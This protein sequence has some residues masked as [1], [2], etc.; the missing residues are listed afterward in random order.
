MIEFS[1]PLYTYIKSKKFNLNLNEYRNSHYRVLAK[2]KKNVEKIIFLKLR[3]A[4]KIAAPAKVTITLWKEGKRR[5][6]LS[7]VC[8]IADKFALDAIVKCNIIEDDNC[9]VVPFVEYIYGGIDRENPRIHIKLESLS[10]M[11]PA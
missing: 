10:G 11:S 9:Q 6:D 4:P 5:R 2:A 3:G 7:N 1:I 8:S